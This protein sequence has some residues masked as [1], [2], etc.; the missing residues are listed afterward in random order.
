MKTVSEIRNRR[1]TIN[2]ITVKKKNIIT[3]ALLLP[4]ALLAWAI[5]WLLYSLD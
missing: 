3:R 1:I 2:K 5:G 4:A